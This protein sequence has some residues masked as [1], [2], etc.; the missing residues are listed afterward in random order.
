M[1]NNIKFYEFAKENKG[2]QVY[3]NSLNVLLFPFLPLLAYFIIKIMLG[4]IF[5]HNIINPKLNIAFIVICLIL[6]IIWAIKYHKSLKGVFIYDDCFQI[7]TH[8]FLNHYILP[9]N[10]KIYYNEIKEISLENKKSGSYD[11]WNEKHLY[12]IAGYYGKT[13]KY[14]RVETVYGRIYCFCV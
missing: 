13:D 11:K 1:N 6:G 12:F 2:V 8:F 7:E 4:N 14:I 9:F 3:D 10:P 5:K